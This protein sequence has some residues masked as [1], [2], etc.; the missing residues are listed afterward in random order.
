[1]AVLVWVLLASYV[2][3][4]PVV[5]EISEKQDGRFCFSSKAFVQ[6]LIFEFASRWP[7]KSFGSV[8]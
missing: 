5:K 7:R 8:V 1:L 3:C 4:N 2:L 6:S